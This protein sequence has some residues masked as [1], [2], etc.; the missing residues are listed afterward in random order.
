MAETTAQVPSSTTSEKQ[1]ISAKAMERSK[2]L[3]AKRDEINKSQENRGVDFNRVVENNPKTSD[4]PNSTKVKISR[5][6]SS[7]ME[8]K[9]SPKKPDYQVDDKAVERNTFKKPESVEAKTE[10]TSDPFFQRLA[11]LQTEEK[12]TAQDNLRG[13]IQ[14]TPT[15][16]NIDVVG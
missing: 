7:L 1:A 13:R 11:S 15:T 3:K 2:E 4:F 8:E 6:L 5:E 12:P 16:R 10:S 9:N 14:L